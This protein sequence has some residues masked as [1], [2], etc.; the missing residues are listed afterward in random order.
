MAAD[1]IV[2]LRKDVFQQTALGKSN[3]VQ[4]IKIH[5]KLFFHHQQINQKARAKEKRKKIAQDLLIIIPKLII[6]HI[7]R[8]V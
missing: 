2:D 8:H 6:Y 1:K 5:L 7:Q 3:A 4:I